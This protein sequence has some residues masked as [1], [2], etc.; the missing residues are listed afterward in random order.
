M[1][2]EDQSGVDTG[3]AAPGG[4]EIEQAAPSNAA[5]G[6]RRVS[7]GPTD[8]QQAT[9]G[10]G[11]AAQ[12]A[13]ATDAATLL[14][15]LLAA[16]GTNYETL[17]RQVETAQSG[18]PGDPASQG[19][20]QTPADPAR[21]VRDTG[22]DSQ[23]GRRDG[24]QTAED[25]DA[26]I[27]A[28]TGTPLFSA[29]FTA[30]KEQR[31]LQ[32]PCPLIDAL[33]AFDPQSPDATVYAT[34]DGYTRAREQL[35]GILVR[36]AEGLLILFCCR[37]DAKDAFNPDGSDTFWGLQH[38]HNTIAAVSLSAISPAKDRAARIP[39]PTDL[40]QASSA[41]DFLAL[42]SVATQRR[43][44][45]NICPIPAYLLGALL[46][47]AN[48]PTFG[49]AAMIVSQS[50]RDLDAKTPGASYYGEKLV[51]VLEWL[52]AAGAGAGQ[53]LPAASV[54]VTSQPGP[55]RH[56]DLMLQRW[57]PGL[58]PQNSANH[59]RQH[60]TSSPSHR[61]SEQS[62]AQQQRSQMANTHLPT[63]PASDHRPGYNISPN[64]ISTLSAKA[65]AAGAAAAMR[66]IHFSEGDSHRPPPPP[67]AD[68]SY[69]KNKFESVWPE[70]SQRA[71]INATAAYPPGTVDS[72]GD[73]ISGQRR[74]QPLDL[75]RR[76]VESSSI[77]Q[78]E[79]ELLQAVR[80]QSNMELP[81][82][83]STVTS[84]MTGKILNSERAPCFV[85][86]FNLVR[87]DTNI[88]L[89]LE[90]SAGITE[91]DLQAQIAQRFG[92]GMNDDQAKRQAKAVWYAPFTVNEMDRAVTA[93]AALW[94]A[95]TSDDCEHGPLHRFWL[96]IKTWIDNNH[97][98]L[99]VRASLNPRLPTEILA[100]AQKFHDLYLQDCSRLGPDG[101]P[102]ERKLLRMQDFRDQVLI[103]INPRVTLPYYVTRL[104]TL[105]LEKEQPKSQQKP[106][107]GGGGR[108]GGG[109]NPTDDSH[110]SKK[111]R[112]DDT[113]PGSGGEGSASASKRRS[114][115]GKKVTNE[116][117]RDEAVAAK[118]LQNWQ[119]FLRKI[120]SDWPETLPST[121]CL[122]FHVRGI[123][124]DE[125]K[126][127]HDPLSNELSSK[128]W[129]GCRECCN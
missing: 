58:D 6:G 52:W 111:K 88:S 26:S 92:R 35:T 98:D 7:F 20:E 83:V 128:L 31:E 23:T 101:M 118:C 33:A 27:E 1:D 59:R 71:L 15:R 89:H 120:L 4:G 38:L 16:S 50:I 56:R 115:R 94:R 32:P 96:E 125:C 55:L 81:I 121:L 87:P 37:F 73:D 100:V 119:T 116:A 117:Q 84:I 63:T 68:N 8:P 99:S 22:S 60:T 90:S 109:G 30:A 129:A 18:G 19:T 103:G 106:G 66:A 95:L 28:F 43:F 72:N 126:R 86:V 127:S 76:I 14:Q 48:T 5:A 123:C 45:R 9:T 49:E 54:F 108:G 105:R 124:H 114:Q 42:Q 97:S 25:D 39:P 69:K 107:G 51:F 75:I 93:A 17:L 10:G 13:P 24:T 102:D 65:A 21:S 29:I 80:D 2:G 64:T 67:P 78:A 36:S 44:L 34:L 122:N 77:Q 104:Y 74:S 47:R 53:R 11:T 113:T 79:D 57:F 62:A 46:Q 82:A 40:L 41:A 91:T 12:A 85:T 70:A 3:L 110:S 61:N 112:K